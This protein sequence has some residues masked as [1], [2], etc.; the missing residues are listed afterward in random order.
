MP[1]YKSYIVPI[2]TVVVILMCVKMYS[3]NIFT[4]LIKVKSNIDDREYYVQNLPD[5][6][7]ASN[8]LAIIR[9]KLIKIVDYL[10]NK[11]PENPDII[12]LKGNFRPDRINEGLSDSKYTSYS[13]NKGEKIVMC[14]RQRDDQKNLV[15]LNTLTFVAIHELA[16]LMTQSIGH[17]DDFWFN[18]EFILKEVLHSPLDVYQYQAFHKVPQKYCGTTITDTPYKNDEPANTHSR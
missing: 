11:Y 18:M 5:K 9:A 1:N 7:Q 17:G 10:Y 3:E 16:H 8:N 4:E 2:V 6:Q 13:V 15:D 12:R 14:I